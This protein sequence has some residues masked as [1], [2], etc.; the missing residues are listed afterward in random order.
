MAT[1]SANVRV[2]VRVTGDEAAARAFRR[3]SDDLH[4][5]IEEADRTVASQTAQDARSRAL[6]IGGVA[7]HV[8]PSIAAQGADTTFGGSE[9]PMAMGAE[10]G[11]DTY[12][13]FDPHTGSGETAGYFLIPTILDSEDDRLREYENAADAA[14]RGFSR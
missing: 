6:M 8:A 3:L 9:W 7:A 13:Q 12:P 5:R 1:S 11:R 10:F 2:S 4:D 14:L